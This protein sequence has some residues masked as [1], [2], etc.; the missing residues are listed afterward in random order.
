MSAER[1]TSFLSWFRDRGVQT[2]VLTAVVVAALVAALLGTV[3]V[4][5]L[6]STNAAATAMYENNF[7]GFQHVATVRRS[8][9]EM[10]LEAAN[11]VISG[12]EEA[13]A[14]ETAS[15]AAETAGREA[16]A[17]YRELD[18][19]P[20]QEALLDEVEAALDGYVLIRDERMFPAGREGDVEAWREAREVAGAQI[21]P[22]MDALQALVDVEKSDAAGA[23]EQSTTAYE[24]VR[25]LVILLL[26]VGLV[27]ALGLGVLIARSIV[28]GLTRVRLV[29]EALERGDLTVTA[30]L[31]S[32]DEVG[33]MGSALDAAVGSL[34]TVVT[35]IDASS[36]TLAGAAEEMSSTSAQIA[37]NAEETASQAGVVSAAAEQVSRSVQTVAAGAE[38]MGSSIAEIASN[39]SQAAQVAGQAVDAAGATTEVMN[40]LGESSR[41][42]G[43]VVK[44]ITSIAEQTNLLALN[45]TIEAA[46]AGEA[47]KGF[48]VVAGEVK[49]LAQETARATE[50]IARRVEGIQEDTLGAV[51]A[52]DRISQ[53][54]ASINDFQMTIAS[55]V[56][57]QTATT[58]EIS[59][60]VAEAATGSGEI[61]AN[62]AAVAGAAQLTTQGAAESQQAV[63]ELATMSTELKTLVGRFTA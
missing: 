11:Q 19:T 9:L 45:A 37:A 54:I 40:R 16:L 28:G 51:T 21:D 5:A 14:H 39:A 22:M 53:V 4:A 62:I 42:I 27:L 34:R 3:G 33:R 57:E 30:G 13:D 52:I 7:T 48:A 46:R 10:R 20:E 58:S 38:Q 63:S 26:V 8:V 31:T 50:D 6:A 47:G 32:A 44:V 41:Q 29:C 60:S 12:T 25:T 18:V 59:R 15:R 36:G 24:G 61:A 55:A 49:E 56:E 35:T 2:R 43:N 17:A 1:R 23:V